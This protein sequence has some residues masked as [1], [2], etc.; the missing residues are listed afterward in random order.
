MTLTNVFGPLNYRTKCG[1]R[2]KH[3]FITDS[4]SDRIFNR[5]SG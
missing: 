3:K 5:R 2:I 4:E 1:R